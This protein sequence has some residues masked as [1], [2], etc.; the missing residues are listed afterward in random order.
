MVMYIFL[1][2]PLTSLLVLSL[3]KYLIRILLVFD[4]MKSL[5]LLAFLLFLTF[6]HR[7]HLNVYV[8]G[9]EHH[10]VLVLH[11]NISCFKATSMKTLLRK[12]LVMNHETL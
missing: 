7:G 10:Y 4:E 9:F 6:E 3:R 11:E 5:L 1:F 12:Q 8:Y 2:L